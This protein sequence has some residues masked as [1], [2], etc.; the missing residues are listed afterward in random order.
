MLCKA[1]TYPWR[2]HERP[3]LDSIEECAQQ[4]IDAHGLLTGTGVRFI[5]AEHAGN[6][7][8]S[9]EEAALI[10][11]AIPDLLRGTVTLADNT[12]RRLRPEDLMVVTPYNAQVRCLT[13]RLPEGVRVGT[14]DKFQ[15]QEAQVVFFSMATS[16]GA[17]APRNVEFLYSRNRLNVAVSCARCLAVLVCNPELLHLEPRSIEQMRLANALCRLVELAQSLD[18]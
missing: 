5:E 10:A 15:G 4:R 14:V 18:A 17:E 11:A 12:T 3:S 16:S 9:S 1:Q 7:R 13:E 2:D 6:T 8:E